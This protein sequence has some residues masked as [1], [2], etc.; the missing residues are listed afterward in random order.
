MEARP[1]YNTKR[2]PPPHSVP[3][4][5]CPFSIIKANYKSQT[6]MPTQIAKF[7]SAC[8]VWRVCCQHKSNTTQHK[9][10]NS[11]APAGFGACVANTNPTQIQ[12]NPT[13]IAKFR[14]ACW[15]WRVRCQH[16]SNT[17]NAK[18]LSPKRLLG[19]A[20]A[21]PPQIQHNIS[22]VNSGGSW[23]IC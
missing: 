13:Q 23:L 17:T 8:W 21:L 1:G 16:K 15:V 9:W 3:R 4:V 6:R 18:C 20:H 7:P 11:A 12:H 19:L 14:S 22:Q 5:C 2:T 10:P